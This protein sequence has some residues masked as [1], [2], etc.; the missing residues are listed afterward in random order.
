MRLSPLSMG[1]ATILL[2]V[3]IYFT[4]ALLSKSLLE[5]TRLDGYYYLP[6]LSTH[7]FLPWVVAVGIVPVVLG[8]Y[9][10]S[11]GSLNEVI[12]QLSD[13]GVISLSEDDIDALSRRTKKLYESRA[14]RLLML[15][16]ATIFSYFVFCTRHSFTLPID[17]FRYYSWTAT[18]LAQVVVTTVT[19]PVVYMGTGLVLN[20]LANIS[21]LHTLFARE[22]S[23]DEFRVNPLHPDRCGGL[24]PLSRYSLKTVFLCATTGL[25]VGLIVL[26]QLRGDSANLQ[27]IAPQY[28]ALLVIEVVFSGV[29]FFGPLWQ[30]HDGMALAKEKLLG[31]IAHE[32][33]REYGKGL[34]NITDDI[35][36]ITKHAE[37]IA[38]LKRFYAITDE[39]PVWPFNASALRQFGL[40]LTAPLAPL[41]LT[42]AGSLLHT[43]LGLTA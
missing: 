40:S 6:L 17:G 35:A 29:L 14:K 28:I 18:P 20:L 1:A 5:S 39:F 25:L 15:L 11:F 42:V 16:S 43:L 32:Y 4:T 22:L 38:A 36:V 37:K 41:L 33:D 23:Q 10:W 3:I 9:L 31:L 24:R 34:D 30:A 8:Y 19:F 27:D 7:D 13:T 21:L 2:S 12:T 26:Q